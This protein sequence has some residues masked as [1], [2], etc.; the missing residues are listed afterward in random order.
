M[1]SECALYIARGT[2]SW[3]KTGPD[4]FKIRTTFSWF[5]VPGDLITTYIKPKVAQQPV[6]FTGLE[7]SRDQDEDT[8]PGEHIERKEVRLDKGQEVEAQTTPFQ[9]EDT[10]PRE[11]CEIVSIVRGKKSPSHTYRISESHPREDNKKPSSGRSSKSPAR[12]SQDRNHVYSKD[13]TRIWSTEIGKKRE[14]HNHFIVPAEK[15]PRR[16]K[17]N[18]VYD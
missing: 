18:K 10:Y 4:S 8:F 16:S 6:K 11:D 1:S 15:R 12:V 14:A 7:T 3:Y 13:Y 2:R 9:D 5:K 17:R